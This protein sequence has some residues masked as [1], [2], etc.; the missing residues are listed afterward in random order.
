MGSSPGPRGLEARRGEAGRSPRRDTCVHGAP[1][2]RASP[3]WPRA[4]QPLGA[5][6][7]SSPPPA[8]P[9]VDRRTRPWAR[10]EQPAEPWAATAGCRGCSAAT[11]SPRSPTG[12]SSSASACASPSWGPRCWTSAAKRT[13]RCPRSPG[14]SSRSSSASCWAAPSGASSKGRECRARAPLHIPAA[15]TTCP[16]GLGLS[17]GAASLPHHKLSRKTL[18]GLKVT[19]GLCICLHLPLRA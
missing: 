5:P 10:C 9:P 16:A 3:R 6:L 18:P 2:R 1:D 11:C 7:L 14:S 19:S 8:R 15:A 17:P 4:G 13:A 12:A